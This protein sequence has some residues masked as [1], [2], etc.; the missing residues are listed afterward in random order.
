MSTLAH[1][2]LWGVR[3]GSVSFDPGYPAARFEYDPDFAASGIQPS[4]FAMPLSG[5]VYSF[6]HLNS[7]TFRGLP[8][9]LSDSLPD[10]FGNA[11]VDAWLVSQGR[12]AGSL[13]PVER[14]CYTGSRG[15]GALEYVP[16][17]GPDATPG[18]QLE[19]DR[20]V[21]LASAILSQRALAHASADQAGLD[22]I[23]SVG[24]SAGGARA[25]AIVAWNE[26]TGDI[27]SGQVQAG[28]GYGYWVMKL[29][30]MQDNA[31][32]EDRDPQG[33]TLI[34]YAYHL[35]ARQSGISM[36][37]CRLLEDGRLR[38]FLSRRFDRDAA[39]GKK[40]HMQTLGALVHADYNSPGSYSYEQAA[41]TIC[42]L[43][44]GQDEVEQLFRRM[45][46]NVVFRNQDDHVKNISFLMDRN[47]TWSLAPAYDITYAYQL[48][49]MWTGTH[50]MAVNGKRDGFERVDL[51][52]SARTMGI[53][54]GRAQGILDDV[55][56]S[57]AQWPRF[58]EEAG[59][60]EQVA[61]RLQDAFRL[62]L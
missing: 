25:K 41:Q 47:G 12:P 40:I 10:K 18:Q 37:E 23:L 17:I 50:Q 49:G 6:P 48:G 28:R 53:G 38:H 61:H 36:P 43:G 1:V 56:D 34:E 31:D 15:M 46:F 32:K 39:T 8:G 11:V 44:M 52:Q 2:I 45:C 16:A 19:I 57:A 54:K 60:D 4:P 62:D 35:L 59:M 30:G 22:Q 42:G 55:L 51:L 3:I 20:L 29:D 9:L 26:Q 13:N 24:T 21:E 58:A 33:Y 7:A 27:R 14:L 5:Q